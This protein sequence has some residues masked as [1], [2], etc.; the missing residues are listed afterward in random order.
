MKLRGSKNL[1]FQSTDATKLEAQ[2]DIDLAITSIA[3]AD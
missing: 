1:D 3:A 2:E